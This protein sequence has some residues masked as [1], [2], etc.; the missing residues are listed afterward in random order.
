MFVWYDVGCRWSHLMVGF[1]H[2]FHTR[3]ETFLQVLAE[4]KV[5]NTFEKWDGYIGYLDYLL[6]STFNSN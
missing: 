3:G 6:K 1:L 4:T 2:P 5:L